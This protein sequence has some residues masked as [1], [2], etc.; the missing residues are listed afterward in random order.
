MSVMI[1]LFQHHHN[2]A[3]LVEPLTKHLD[4]LDALGD[5]G[6][7]MD[8]SFLDP[9]THQTTYAVTK[10]EV[11]VVTVVIGWLQG[12]LLVMCSPLTG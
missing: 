11:T 9:D 8:E 10:P 12:P 5:D 1:K 6:M 7:S 2:I 4:I 3:K